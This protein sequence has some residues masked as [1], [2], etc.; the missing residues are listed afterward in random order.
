MIQI[1][2]KEDIKVSFGGLTDRELALEYQY[3]TLGYLEIVNLFSDVE[4]IV[5]KEGDE[6]IH[7]Y[8]VS[9]LCGVDIGF[10]GYS[11]I[12]FFLSDEKEE[13][14]RELTGELAE[15]RVLLGDFEGRIAN[16]REAI[17]GLGDGIP[18][19]TKLIAFLNAVKESIHYD[20]NNSDD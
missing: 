14:I 16:V 7:Q 2:G 19:L 5:E 3:G 10:S 8:E 6:I 15:V 20:G 13:R 11:T 4:T 1:V 17:K 12:R 9:G 18:T